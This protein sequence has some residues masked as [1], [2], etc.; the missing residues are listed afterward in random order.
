S[1]VLITG[2]TG[3]GKE[4]LAR[5]IHYNSLR[6][7]H[8]IITVDCGVLSETLLESELFGH[9]KG[10]FTGAYKVRKGLFEQADGG[11]V[12]LD[13]VANASPSVQKKLL[14]VI[15]EKTFERLGGETTHKTDVRIIA[16]TNQNLSQRVKDGTLR[17]DLYYRLN[18]IP[19]YLPALR[20]RK[21]DIPLLA[22]Y[23]LDKFTSQMGR[24][25][26]E[27]SPEVMKQFI[28]YP[29]P[30]NVREV[31]NIMERIAI[32]TV[33]DV[34]KKAPLEINITPDV[35]FSSLTGLEAPLKEQISGIERPYLVEALKLY[36]GSIK[37][38]A[39]KTGL[40]PRTI[41]RKMKRYGLDKNNFKK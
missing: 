24:K 32:V 26:L 37:D 41:H 20:E 17:T 30:G 21:E 38:V 4:L 36:S 1:T 23:F 15:Q 11:T 2:E 40:S 10:A 31:I 5:T 27:I 6:K 34:V 16:A 39:K 3:T 14:R 25:P 9:E 33:D 8:P 22:H 12:F 13:E 19:I 7:S 28:A 35:S 29:W 18:V